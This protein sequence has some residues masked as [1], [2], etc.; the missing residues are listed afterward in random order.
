MICLSVSVLVSFIGSNSDPVVRLL[1]AFKMSHVA[2]AI[3][4][5]EDAVSMGVCVGNHVSVS[6]ILSHHVSVIHILKHWYDCIAGQ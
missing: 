5:V 1:R 2:L 6:A 3:I 4:S